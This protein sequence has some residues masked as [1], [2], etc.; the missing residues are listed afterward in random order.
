MGTTSYPDAFI[1]RASHCGPARPTLGEES[2]RQELGPTRS[3]R[4]PRRPPA[5]HTSPPSIAAPHTPR[6]PP[7]LPSHTRVVSSSCLRP[8]REYV[9]VAH[10][11]HLDP[12]IPSYPVLAS[13]PRVSARLVLGPV[14]ASFA[15]CGRT[16]LRPSTWVSGLKANF[17]RSRPP[18]EQRREAFKPK[19]GWAELGPQPPAPKRRVLEKE[20]RSASYTGKRYGSGPSK[21]R[22]ADPP[23]RP[24]P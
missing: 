7:Q 11:L 10:S 8:E 14:D 20:S 12:P 23:P 16:L 2:R 3:L 4:I 17:H 18:R 21:E 19:H 24:L 15:A 22:P 5:A 13:A 9:Y 6:S 1:S